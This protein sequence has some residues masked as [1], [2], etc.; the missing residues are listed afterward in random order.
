MLL[1]R[2]KTLC[3]NIH[4]KTCS[5]FSKPVSEHFVPLL[6][7]F[8]HCFKSP[9][10]KHSIFSLGFNVERRLKYTVTAAKSHSNLLNKILFK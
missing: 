3:L 4:E 5:F 6:S 8:P 10:C 9:S 7:F 2:N 1:L